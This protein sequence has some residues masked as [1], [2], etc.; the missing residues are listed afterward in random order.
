MYRK[1]SVRITE[2]QTD[3]CVQLM[4]TEE[5]WLRTCTQ[6]LSLNFNIITS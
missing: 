5:K 3:I 4:R 6:W 2:I 1:R